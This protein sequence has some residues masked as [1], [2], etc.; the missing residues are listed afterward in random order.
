MKIYI[1]F[2]FSRFP[3]V[4]RESPKFQSATELET[5][6]HI[7]ACLVRSKDRHINAQKKINQVQPDSS[8]TQDE[9]TYS[10]LH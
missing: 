8:N 1:L 9:D 5:I 10:H 7:K 4:V 2:N 3:D 6:N